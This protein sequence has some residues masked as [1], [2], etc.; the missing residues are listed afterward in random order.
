[1]YN[2]DLPRQTPVV[3]TLFCR[4]TNYQGTQG[5][6]LPNHRVVISP[7]FDSRELKVILPI[8]GLSF[9]PVL[10]SRELNVI[11]PIIELLF[12]PVVIAGDSR[13]PK[14]K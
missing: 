2:K 5:H 10:I 3:Y 1:M 13:S 6:S 8:I 14:G 9:P 7:S 4:L 12:P 11:L